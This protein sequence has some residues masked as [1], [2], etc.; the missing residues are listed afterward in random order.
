MF[1]FFRQMRERLLA[2]KKISKFLLSTIWEIFM[3]VLGILIAL[4]V[5]NWNEDRKTLKSEI[6]YLYALHDEFST[7]LEVVQRVMRSNERNL[8][9]AL[10][11]MGMMGDAGTSSDEVNFDT[12]MFGAMLAEIQYRPSPGTMNELISS[13]KLGIISNRELRLKLASWDG[14]LTSIRFQEE[15]HS[16]PRYALIDLLNREG[17]YRKSF[18]HT[19]GKMFGIPDSQFGHSSK[20]LAQ[21]AEFDNQ[22]THFY[23]TGAFLNEPYY[24]RLKR[25]IEST[26]EMIE[27]ELADKD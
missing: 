5:N 25:E 16:K 8:A 6:A 23:M 1:N 26:I 22:L 17:N 9:D 11:L 19:Y 20:E 4:Q 15:E 21:S 10:I 12:L 24:A 27:T 13:G 3:V 7:N 2:D 18:I 14:I